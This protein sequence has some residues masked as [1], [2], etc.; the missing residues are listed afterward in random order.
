[1]HLDST[2]EEEVPPEAEHAPITAVDTVLQLDTPN[3]TRA[4][5]HRNFAYWLGSHLDQMCG[6]GK[7]QQTLSHLQTNATEMALFCISLSTVSFAY[8]SHQML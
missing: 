5:G 7:H 6:Q 8:E 4:K 2:P 3:V 1:M